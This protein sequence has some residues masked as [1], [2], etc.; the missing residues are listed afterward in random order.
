MKVNKHI[1]IINAS[2]RSGK[3]TLCNIVADRYDTD[4]F[5]VLN[6]SSVDQVKH[7]AKILGW[8]GVSKNDIDRKFLSDLKD[9]ATQYCDSPFK[10]EYKR[11]RDFMGT[12]SPGIMFIHI[13]EP[14]E[15][16]KLVDAFPAIK[17]LYIKNDNIPKITTNHADANTENYEY[18][19]YIDNNG[20]LEDFRRTVLKFFEEE[21]R[22]E[23]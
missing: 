21:L 3:D 9:L 2:G 14:E 22:Y 12:I 15:I 5:Q 20:T 7:C 13:R 4:N 6:I 1:Y 11:I 17:T 10:Y 23:Y 8:D 16:K 18:D 19:Y